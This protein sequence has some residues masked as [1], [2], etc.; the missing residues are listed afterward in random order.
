MWSQAE[1]EQRAKA[2]ATSFCA[3][4][5]VGGNNLSTL[6]EK[7]ARDNNLNPEQI[8]RL[9]RAANTEVFGMKYASMK[10]VPDRRVDFEIVD[11]EAVISRLQTPSQKTASIRASDY[12][13]LP[14]EGAR[15]QEKTAAEII[16]PHLAKPVPVIARWRNLEKLAQELPIELTQLNIRWQS[17]LNALA[18]DCRAQ[19]HNHVEF[20]KNAAGLLGPEILPEL[21]AVRSLLK[22]ERLTTSAEKIAEAQ[23]FLV[24][25]E[26]K[27]TRFLS[28]ALSARKEYATKVATLREVKLALTKARKEVLRVG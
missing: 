21:N 22:M 7:V 20:E 2:I 4:E 19:G 1:Y 28:T 18:E 3:A 5:D 6:V 8:R 25:V 23:D 15:V 26:T 17:S 24:G 16:D 14:R 27:E 9:S 12:P 11:A 10:T 13:D